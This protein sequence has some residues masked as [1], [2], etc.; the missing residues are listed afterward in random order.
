MDHQ[1]KENIDVIQQ[2]LMYSNGIILFHGQDQRQLLIK[3]KG[4]ILQV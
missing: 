2:E 3:L 1:L 4:M